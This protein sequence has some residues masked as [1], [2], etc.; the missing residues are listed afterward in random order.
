MSANALSIIDISEGDNV[1]V[2]AEYSV[3]DT[4]LTVNI[5][6][7]TYNIALK[8]GKTSFKIPNLMLHNITI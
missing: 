5:A 8:D 1:I 4:K 2:N 3:K 7:K 6:D